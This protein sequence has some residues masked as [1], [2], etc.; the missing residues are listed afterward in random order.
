MSH[1]DNNRPGFSRRQGLGLL[2][3]P[4]CFLAVYL[5][6]LPKAMPPEALAVAAVAV[7]MAIWWVTEAIPIPATAVIPIALFPALGIMGSADTTANYANHLIYL[8][9]GGF[10]IAAG[11]EKWG[12]HRRIALHILRLV[13][14]RP[15]RIVLGFM[16]A[17][18]FLSM[19][20]SNTATAMMMLPMGT[21]IVSQTMA[22]GD[23]RVATPGAQPPQACF[24]T[25]LMLGIAYAASIGGV[26]TLIGTPPNA[27]L[28]G[29]VE[30]LYGQRIS[31]GAWLAFGLP[32][33]LVMLLLCWLYLTRIAFRSEMKHLATSDAYIEDELQRLGPASKEERR[34]LMVFVAVASAWILRGL[35]D[36]SA[37]TLVHDSTIAMTGALLLFMIPSNLAR[38]EFLLDWKTAVK[39]PW[40]V[41]ILFGGGFALAH[42]F[43]ES[44]LTAWIGQQLPI[45]QGA[46]PILIVLMV[47]TVTIFLTE[48][49]S[50]TAT[51]SMLL[52]V[53]ASL[54]AGAGIHPYGPMVGAALA[55]SFAFMLPVATPPNAIVYASRCVSIPQM[56][57]AGFGLNI[58]GIVMIVLGVSAVLP[59]LWG[60]SL[61]QFPTGFHKAP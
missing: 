22:A 19:W 51:A 58:L 29:V 38:G 59:W 44:G 13:G 7:L 32:L 15:E 45:F 9:L 21:A 55:A 1:S 34:V 3:G 2:L 16:L 56:A 57:R 31:F 24:A 11:I 36:L 27:V 4:A 52:P 20:L 12:L 28:A 46:N 35:V 53:F 17:T 49:T 14:N 25:A 37:L 33:S 48:L 43:Q 60:F 47:S 5:L 39:I 40:D 54:A 41:I 42:G 8:F 6:P 30:T 61:D 50:N 10:W 18:A 26:A 23:A